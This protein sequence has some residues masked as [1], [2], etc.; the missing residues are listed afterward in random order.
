MKPKHIFINNFLGGIAWGLGA[1]IGLTV[2]LAVFGFILGKIDFIPFVGDFVS[3]VIEY[4]QKNPRLI[5]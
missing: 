5:K 2:V 3:S 4:T 1:T